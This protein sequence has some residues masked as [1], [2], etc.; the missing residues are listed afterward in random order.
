LF[1]TEKSMIRL[2][3]YSV[4]VS[5]S[6][7]VRANGDNGYLTFGE[8]SDFARPCSILLISSDSIL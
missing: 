3:I 1:S 2:I 6:V 7:S 4:S 8:E 5:E